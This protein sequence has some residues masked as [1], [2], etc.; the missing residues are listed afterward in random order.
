MNNCLLFAGD[1]HGALTH[2]ERL[3][4]S[5]PIIHLGD[6]APLHGR[7]I[8]ALSP[9]LAERFWFIPG[10]HDFD[11]QLY[12]DQLMSGGLE[13]RNLHAVVRE[14]SGIRVAGLGGVFMQRVWH[15]GL[16]P[17]KFA[18]RES[19]I[20]QLP[21]KDRHRLPMTVAGA[22]WFEDYEAL[23][24]QKADILV[25]HEAPGCHRNGFDDLDSLADAMGCRL[26]VHGHHHQYYQ[27]SVNQGRT[28][29]LGVGYRG[30]C[31][32][33]GNRLIP[34][35]YDEQRMGKWMPDF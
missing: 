31:D 33:E 27:T 13:E 26:I 34:G 10:N 9:T 35:T 23:F 17:P 7:L 6:V 5:L 25:T 8:E 28:R 29:V 21:K 30:V 2:L 15:P 3:K 4:T 19:Y 11:K 18:T 1:T 24:D 14:I 16:G 32:V 12:M 20:S 22:V